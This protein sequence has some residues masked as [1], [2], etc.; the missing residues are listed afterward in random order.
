M[1]TSVTLGNPLDPNPN[2]THEA[3][4]HLKN[5]HDAMFVFDRILARELGLEFYQM[6]N[7]CVICFNMTSPKYFFK[8]SF[9]YMTGQR[10][11]AEDQLYSR[12][13]ASVN[14]KSKTFREKGTIPSLCYRR[15]KE[16][17][18]MHKENFLSSWLTKR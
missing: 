17:K 9:M 1:H 5:D 6:L 8:R 10:H 18:A 16:Y 11:V 15:H 7:G 4:Q 2:S 13:L 14:K 12:P 3:Y